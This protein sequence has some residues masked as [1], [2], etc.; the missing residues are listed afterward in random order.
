MKATRFSV[1][2]GQDNVIHIPQ[3]TEVSPGRA[4]VVVIQD[5]K[6]ASQAPGKGSLAARLAGVAKELG[7][8]GLPSDLAENHDHYAHGSPKGIDQR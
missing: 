7:V 8:S 6:A 3:G 5:E 4:E 1:E 2:I